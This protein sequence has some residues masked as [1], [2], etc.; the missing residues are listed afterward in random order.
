MLIKCHK[1]DENVW[2]NTNSIHITYVFTGI[3][4][5]TQNYLLKFSSI[6]DFTIFQNGKIPFNTLNIFNH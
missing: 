2:N 1:F 3:S 4:I 5:N 6:N